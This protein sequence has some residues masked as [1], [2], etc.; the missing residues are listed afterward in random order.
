M[1]AV[2]GQ[3][4][5]QSLKEKSIAA[6]VTSPSKFVECRCPM[7]K[8]AAIK[9]IRECAFE[10]ES[11]LV[12]RNILFVFGAV[13]SLEFFDVLC[14][15]HNFMH[16]T[17]IIAAG[18]LNSINFYNMTLDGRLAP[19]L[20]ELNKDGTTE[21]KLSVLRHAMNIH[22]NAK[23]VGDYNASKIM[24]NTE[25]IIGNVT[26]SLGFV[27]SKEYP[28]FFVPN[29]VLREDI[30]NIVHKP[31]KRVLAIFIKD[32]NADTYVECTYV[33]KGISLE[34]LLT[35]ETLKTKINIEP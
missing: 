10:Y 25:K 13:N 22:K 8:E 23:M 29:T 27:L 14:L 28:D 1:P 16:L 32:K 33:A 17:G 7:N 11:N 18:S 21:M 12:N 24:L 31:T 4:K 34:E 5:N 19:E 20:F 15:S 9:I 26:A 2:G 35:H 6:A 30:R 3:R